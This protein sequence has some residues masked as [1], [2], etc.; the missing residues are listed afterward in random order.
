MIANQPA[1]SITG[2][3][4]GPGPGEGNFLSFTLIQLNNEV[5][6]IQLGNKGYQGVFDQIL[7][8]FKF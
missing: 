4:A 5:L 7:S 3:P 8:T 2:T 1:V 6:V